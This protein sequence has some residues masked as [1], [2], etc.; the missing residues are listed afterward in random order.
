MNTK[1]QEQILALLDSHGA[2]Y[3]LLR[4]EPCRTSAESARTR[5]AAGAP[6]AIGG[7]ALLAVI[8]GGLQGEETKSYILIVL[9]GTMKLDSKAIR[10]QYPEL[11]RF[12]FA[13]PE[14]MQF[15]CGVSPGE[16]P[17]FGRSIFPSISRMLLD[18][19]LLSYEWVGFNAA[20][21][22]T[23]IVVK[24]ADYLRAVGHDVVVGRFAVP[25]APQIINAA[26][27]AGSGDNSG[28]IQRPLKG[29]R[30]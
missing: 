25:M 18:E 5:A 17:P 30:V 12:R 22:T 27:A 4:H 13:T 29:E 21:F 24:T 15:T 19:S 11:K 3:R 26:P 28:A 1:A 8:E 6:D 23:S 10:V 2:E 14:E 20:E 16:M 7:K 9:P